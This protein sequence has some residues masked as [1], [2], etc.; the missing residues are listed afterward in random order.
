MAQQSYKRK[1]IFINK[2]MQGRYIFKIVLIFTLS[3]IAVTLFLVL[4]TPDTQTMVYNNYQLKLG[5]I[6]LK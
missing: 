6:P 5:S 4:I 1:K 3:A 2:E